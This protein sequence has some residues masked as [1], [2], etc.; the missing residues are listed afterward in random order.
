MKKT[1]KRKSQNL[2]LSLIMFILLILIY[3]VGFAAIS[4]SVLQILPIGKVTGLII[5]IVLALIYSLLIFTNKRMGEIRLW[6]I[7]IVR[8]WGVL[9]FLFSIWWGYLLYQ[10]I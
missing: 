3:V 9:A 4:Q 8:W 1:V 7:P 10:S 5:A 2:L 6:F